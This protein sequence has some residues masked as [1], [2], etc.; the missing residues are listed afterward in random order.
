LVYALLAKDPRLRPA[1]A[2]TVIERLRGAAPDQPSATEP[3]SSTAPISRTT[4]APTLKAPAT[5]VD[6]GLAPGGS[7]SGSGNGREDWAFMGYVTVLGAFVIATIV[8]LAL[9]L[10][11]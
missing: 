4:T 8:V 7:G 6:E 5:D 1:D 10:G 2:R 11:T 9:A 3:N